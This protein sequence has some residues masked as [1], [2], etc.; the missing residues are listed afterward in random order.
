MKIFHNIYLFIYIIHSQFIFLMVVGFDVALE[1]FSSDY[2]IFNP[3]LGIQ[4]K[5]NHV[6]IL[7][8]WQGT[9]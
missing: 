7:E 6:K 1:S 9:I 2:S 4:S 3:Y 5:Q 8:I